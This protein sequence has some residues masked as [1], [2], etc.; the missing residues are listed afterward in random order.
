MKTLS[1]RVRLVLLALMAFSLNAVVSAGTFSAQ[2]SFGNST[3]NP[4]AGSLDLL[5]QLTLPVVVGQ[6]EQA[7]GYS[8]AFYT[9]V[10]LVERRNRRLPGARR[11]FRNPATLGGE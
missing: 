3:A 7:C 11:L 1:N 5:Q 2:T 9:R 8:G 4:K 10:Q 6:M